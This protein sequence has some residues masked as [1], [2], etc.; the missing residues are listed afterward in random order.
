MFA[1]M[2]ARPCATSA[3]TNSGVMALPIAECLRAGVAESEVVPG[4]FECRMSNVE[5]M[6]GIWN[7][8]FVWSFGFRISNLLATEIFTDRDEFHFRRDDSLARVPKLR[9]WMTGRCVQR[10]ARPAV[11]PYLSIERWPFDANC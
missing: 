10:T 3:R 9:D 8:E 2:M 4:K 6:I 7:F 1:G 11:A 5:G